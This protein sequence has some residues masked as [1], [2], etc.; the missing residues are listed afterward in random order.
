MTVLAVDLGSSSCKAAILGEGRILTPVVR[1]SHRLLSSGMLEP[2]AAR[3][4]I[5]ETVRELLAGHSRRAMPELPGIDA[6]ALSCFMAFCFLDRHDAPVV[7][8]AAYNDRSAAGS[9]EPLT[10]A[11]GGIRSFAAITGR[12]PAA[13]LA[14]AHL[15]KLRERDRQAVGSIERLTSLKDFL[16]EGLTGARGMDLVHAN[17][18]GLL[19]V[20]LRSP[21]VNLLRELGLPEN[22]LGTLQEPGE[23]AGTLTGEAAGRLNLPE[24]LPVV[25]GAIDGTT[26]M[27]GAGVLL[28]GTATLVCGTTDVIMAHCSK[29]PGESPV[30]TEERPAE[31]SI[32]S[33]VT[34]NTALGGGYLT[35]G[36]TA[37]SGGLISYL[38]ALFGVKCEGLEREIA[39]VGVGAEGLRMLPGIGGERAPFWLPEAAGALRGWR[40]EH[41]RQHFFR[42]AM[43]A[44][45]FRLARVAGEMQECG[46]SFSMVRLAG[47][48]SASEL[49]N[50][51]RAGALASAGVAE[52][53]AG[54][55]EEAT[56]I[57]SGIFCELALIGGDP[58]EATQHW[59][60][61][62]TRVEPVGG[63]AEAA[64][65]REYDRLFE[66]LEEGR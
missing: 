18:T 39:E 33:R 64:L 65:A 5:E 37:L 63:S 50:R 55:T 3:E 17:Y 21:W 9:L 24:G 36:S 40:A 34:T 59:A 66:Q 35:G 58:V 53:G 8:C 43:E 51:I 15:W 47:G 16:L 32:A 30:G 44:T 14:A 12:R 49:W 31:G 20:N 52:T 6:F 23:M 22:L 48:G 38:E 56:L 41:R 54:S 13:E 28:P 57:G 27:Y 60:P 25:R 61:P 26:A 42:A 1:R 19:D 29:G 62:V 7:P 46:A 11:A 4:L 2:K 10:A 45:A